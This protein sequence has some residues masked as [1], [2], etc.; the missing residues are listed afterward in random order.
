MAAKIDIS[1]LQKVPLFEGL[2]RNHLKSI[3]RETQLETIPAGQVVVAEGMPG[4]RMFLILEGLAKVSV[5]GRKRATLGPGDFFGE[6]SLF[7][8]G[9]RSATVTAETGIR[10]LSLASWNFLALLQE[11][12]PM[13]QKVLHVL[14]SR[15]RELERSITG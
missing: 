2:S 7:D 9:P 12:W 13:N 4:G 15:V 8:K 3:L 14:A 11:H 1:V 5:G 6:M 10:A